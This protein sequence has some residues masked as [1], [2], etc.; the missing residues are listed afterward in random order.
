MRNAIEVF[1]HNVFGI[2]RENLKMKILSLSSVLGMLSCTSY[3]FVDA[4]SAVAPTSTTSVPGS[5]SGGGANELDPVDRT[6]DGIDAV[7]S[8][9]PTDGDNAAVKRNNNDQV[10]VPQVSKEKNAVGKG[11][12]ETFKTNDSVGEREK[13]KKEMKKNRIGNS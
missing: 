1:L 13:R 2:K 4:F 11:G 5:K 8:F 7:G 6:L 10:W 12:K 3:L 9:D